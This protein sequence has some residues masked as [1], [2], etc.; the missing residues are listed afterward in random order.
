MTDRE[1]IRLA[2]LD[3]MSWRYSLADANGA[4]ST[5]GQLAAAR[6]GQFREYYERKYGKIVT[7]DVQERRIS[8][9]ALRAGMARIDL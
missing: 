1:L 5:A 7:T 8:L 2:V 6:A 4:D 3:A 9:K